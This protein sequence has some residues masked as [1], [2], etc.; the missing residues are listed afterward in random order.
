MRTHAA[1]PSVALPSSRRAVVPSFQSAVA[2]SSRR[3]VLLLAMT[4]APLGA[5]SAPDL[6]L[7]AT[8]RVAAI[9]TRRYL[10]EDF[11]SAV[12]P[13][14][15]DGTLKV[16]EVGRSG[17]G[18]PI[19]T[20][21]FGRGPVKLLLWSQ[22][23]GNE[24]TATMA[25]ADIFHWMA[26]PGA[27]PR[28][29]RLAER[30]TIVML[31]MLNPDGAARYQRENAWGID[32]NRDARR[33]VTPE[34]RTLKALRDRLEPDFGFNLHDQNTRTRVGRNGQQAAF[35][36]LAP[37]AEKSRS[38]T[39]GRARARR[40]AARMTAALSPHLPG[41]LAR[42]D[43]EWSARAFG[44]WMQSTGTSTVLLETG[45]LDGDPEKQQLRAWNF[46][47]LLAA[48]D[49][50]AA[51][52]EVPGK[53]AAYDDLPENT[54][55]LYDLVVTGGTLRV[56]GLEPVRADLGFVHGGGVGATG[57]LLESVGDLADFAAIDTVDATG[58]DLTPSSEMLE[59]PGA[60]R[61]LLLGAPAE[62]VARRGQGSSAQAVFRITPS[63]KENP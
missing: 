8:H 18:R 33:L 58:L 9:T 50:I 13:S 54:S 43:D 27:D 16:E 11:W 48:F 41:R 39:P 40:L 2:P 51:N 60:R 29:D 10:P 3:A 21:T 30:L 52:A 24:T 15:Q 46:A 12:A 19:R 61:G 32:V 53:T 38:W 55:V 22:M 56:P 36:L 63:G 20:V 14:L 44:D 45:A 62:L 26:A 7:A 34:A 5:Q 37:A 47:A 35:A 59:G 17:E 1:R 4:A 42:Y 49:A 28:R 57:L 31:P 25:L 6:T 23:H